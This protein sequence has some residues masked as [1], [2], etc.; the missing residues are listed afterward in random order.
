LAVTAINAIYHEAR[1]Y[2]FDVGIHPDQFV[3]EQQQLARALVLTQF[4]PEEDD[5]DL[6][7]R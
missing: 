7:S 3:Q 6:T 1:E 5:S 2:G 4:N